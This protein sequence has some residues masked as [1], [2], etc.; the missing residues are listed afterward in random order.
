MGILDDDDHVHVVANNS[1][2]DT[3]W[4]GHTL[5]NWVS[6][7]ELSNVYSAITQQIVL[8]HVLVQLPV[9]PT[10]SSEEHAANANTCNI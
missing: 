8:L 3:V 9:S 10:F 6:Y 2:H 4:F 1:W 7:C 5:V